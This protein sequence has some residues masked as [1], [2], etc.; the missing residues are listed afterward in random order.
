MVVRVATG[1]VSSGSTALALS[2]V[3]PGIL[4]I[5]WGVCIPVLL[6]VPIPVSDLDRV[7]VE[8]NVAGEDFGATLVVGNFVGGFLFMDLREMGGTTPSSL[9]LFP[10]LLVTILNYGNI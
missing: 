4:S 3:L 7:L 6:G 10:S 8:G 1:G 9:S 5:V 2:L